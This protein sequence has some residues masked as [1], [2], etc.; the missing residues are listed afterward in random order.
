MLPTAIPTKTMALAR[1]FLVVPPTL[2]VT[3]D[4]AR[5]KTALDAPVKSG[6]SQLRVWKG[7]KICL[8]VPDQ[9]ASLIV[10]KRHHGE[11]DDRKY[12]DASHQIG[13]DIEVIGLCRYPD[14][15]QAG[16]SETCSITRAV[17]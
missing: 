3:R 5:L 8:T 7:R 13:S 11:P 9:L 4:K 16:R 17:D 6:G 15:D 14:G 1:T 2:P 12:S 10:A